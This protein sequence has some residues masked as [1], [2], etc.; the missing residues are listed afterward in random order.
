LQTESNLTQ[1]QILHDSSSLSWLRGVTVAQMVIQTV[2][3]LSESIIIKWEP[4][5]FNETV[6]RILESIDT[7]KLQD[8]LEKLRRTLNILLAAVKDLNIKID[9]TE[10]TY[11]KTLHVRIWNDLLLDLDRTLL[12]PDESFRSK[13]DLTTFRK[14]S[15]VSTNNTLSYLNNMIKYYE[16]AVQVLQE[17]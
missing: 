12:C 4:K 6:N 7:G 3:R 16:D 1:D 15:L 13:T 10:Y 8:A 5:Y 14:L 11:T 2:W 9:A 17:K